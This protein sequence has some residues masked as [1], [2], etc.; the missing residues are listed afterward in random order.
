MEQ[1]DPATDQTQAWICETC[2][3]P[4]VQGGGCLDDE[5]EILGQLWR[6]IPYGDPREWVLRIPE[7]ASVEAAAAIKDQN[8]RME[9]LKR[10]LPERENCPDCGVAR[11]KAHHPGCDIERCPRCG[12][13]AISCNC[14]GPDA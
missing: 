8:A 9:E 4:M 5:V 13:Q 1:Q 2:G 7:N 6:P 14:F 3:R 12:R 11:G 10:I